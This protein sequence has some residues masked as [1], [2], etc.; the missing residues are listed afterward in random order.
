[1]EEWLKIVTAHTVTIIEAMALIVLAIGTI[2]MF[3][4][5]LRT[6]FGS[7]PTGRDLRDAYLRYARW[8]IAGLTFQLAADIIAT[9]AAPTWDEI[10]RLAAIAVIRTFLNYFLER[11]ILE[12]RAIEPDPKAEVAASKGA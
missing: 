5:C 9:A 12:A 3:F 6:L 7:S 1:M 4:Q 10:G 2:E 11:D 8:L